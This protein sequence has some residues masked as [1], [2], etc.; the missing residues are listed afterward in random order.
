MFGELVVAVHSQAGEDLRR[1][2]SPPPLSPLV[3]LPL[4]P[5]WLPRDG[6]HPLLAGK[7]KEAPKRTK[8]QKKKRTHANTN[9][10]KK[11]STQRE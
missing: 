9:V 8:E 2:G 4:L 5:R 11:H 10:R 1:D 6:R 7:I 3:V